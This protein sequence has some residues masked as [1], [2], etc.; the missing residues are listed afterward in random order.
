M[1]LPHNTGPVPHNPITPQATQEQS[2]ASNHQLFDQ[3]QVDAQR[4][5]WI[6]TAFRGAH[7]SALNQFMHS[8]AQASAHAPY[9]LVEARDQ[10]AHAAAALH[11]QATAEARVAA[12]AAQRATVV[13]PAPFSPKPMP[14]SFGDQLAGVPS[15]FSGPPGPMPV[16]FRDQLAGMAPPFSGPPKPIPVSFR[17]Q[18]AGMAPPFSGPPKPIPVSFRDQLAGVPSPFSGPPGPMPVS[19]RDQLAGAAA[20]SFAP[21]PMPQPLAVLPA[22]AESVATPLATQ[23]AVAPP[24]QVSSS[25]PSLARS[26]ID[27][28]SMETADKAAR[29]ITGPLYGMTTEEAAAY[30]AG[31]ATAS[32]PTTLPVATKGGPS[33]APP[34]DV[35]IV[36]PISAPPANVATSATHPFPVAFAPLSD[37]EHAAGGAAAGIELAFHPYA[38]V[39]PLLEGEAFEHLVESIRSQGLLHAIVLHDGQVLDGRN[40]LRACRAAGVKPRFETYAGSDALAFAT[41]VNVARR[42]LDESQRAM[43]GARMKAMLSEGAKLR[44]GGRPKAGHEKPSADLRGVSGKASE[45]AATMVNV[46]ARSIELAVKVIAEGVPELAHAVDTGRISVSF[47]AQLVSSSP[48]RQRAVVAKVEAGKAPT[49]ALAEVEA[50]RCPVC[51]RT[52][53]TSSPS[54]PAAAAK[55]KLHAKLAKNTSTAKSDKVDDAIALKEKDRAETADDGPAVTRAAGVGT[56]SVP[57]GAPGEREPTA[58][59][60]ARLGRSD[61]KPTKKGARTS[62][63]KTAGKKGSASSMPKKARG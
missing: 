59:G 2:A 19:F 15:P 13:A 17:D 16:S 36:A 9:G 21:S 18:L 37:A 50:E 53:Q 7:D 57:S 3:M 48:E 8:M 26:N 39:F 52:D 25:A 4:M 10:H 5:E 38:N 62:A 29:A 35:V 61:G 32:A 1:Q 58:G 24:T 54:V 41:S 51:G 11:S 43:C 6:P 45:E 49:A 12:E 34:A 42:H 31:L 27:P 30:K 28:H 55:A 56:A 22:G 23:V 47:A 60:A 33:S 40:R 14:V 20:S 46:S 63:S 44:K